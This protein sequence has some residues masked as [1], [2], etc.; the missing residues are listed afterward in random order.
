[1]KRDALAAELIHHREHPKVPTASQL[2][3]DKVHRPA[4]VYPR[5]PIQFEA[6][7][8]GD[9]TALP[10]AYLQVFLAVEAMDQLVIHPPAFPP[11]K[12]V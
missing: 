1:M 12:Q 3:G 8:H 6:R 2:V 9:L 4:L 10:G 11:Q 7:L 5:R